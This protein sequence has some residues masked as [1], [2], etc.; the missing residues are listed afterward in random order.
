MAFYPVDT[1]KLLTAKTPEEME[2]KLNDALQDNYFPV[3]IDARYNGKSSQYDYPYVQTVMKLTNTDP[4]FIAAMA[5]AFK[6]MIDE[7]RTSIVSAVNGVNSSLGTTN[8]RLST[9]NAHLDAIE[10]NTK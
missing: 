3:S 6:P 1:F 9:A 5:A 7:L 10:E 8:S 2:K 4:Q